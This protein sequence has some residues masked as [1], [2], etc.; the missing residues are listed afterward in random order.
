[1]VCNTWEMIHH[2][3]YVSWLDG[4]IDYDGGETM[5]QNHGHPPGD[6]WVWRA[7]VMTT[8]M[9]A[10][11]N[12][13]L[14][15]NSSLAVLPAEKSGA[16]RSENFAYQYLKYLKEYLTCHK[17]LWHGT[18]GFTSHPKEGVLWIF[19]TLKNPSPWPCLNPRPL[20]LVASTLTTTPLRWLHVLVYWLFTVSSS[21]CKVYPKIFIFSVGN[22]DS[23]SKS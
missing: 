4:L 10:G 20:G 13:W 6:M 7:M 15:H 14:I 11:E 16:S 1:L 3:H 18:C 12:S 9:L 8:I 22:R 2:Q 5:S 21:I 19:I 23:E 17:I